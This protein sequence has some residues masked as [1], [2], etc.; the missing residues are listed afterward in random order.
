MGKPDDTYRVFTCDVTN[1]V[2]RGAGVQL[3]YCVLLAINGFCGFAV[4]MPLHSAFNLSSTVLLLLTKWGDSLFLPIVMVMCIVTGCSNRSGQDT[5]VLLTK[6]Y[7]WQR[8]QEGTA[9]QMTQRRLYSSC[10]TE[11]VDREDYK[12]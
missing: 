12:Q 1:H 7:H 4:R 6:S 2:M 5:D 9:Q 8:I 3:G 11:R 10:F